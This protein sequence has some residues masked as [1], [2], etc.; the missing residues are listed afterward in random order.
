M[1]TMNFRRALLGS[2]GLF[3]LFSGTVF[4]QTASNGKTE[5]VIVTSQRRAQ[6][7]RDVPLSITVA[8]AAQLER[9]HIDTV[10][11]IARVSPAV[12]FVD[13][14]PGGGA[15]I[16]GLGTQVFSSSAEASVGI[17]VDGVPQGNVNQSNLFDMARVEVLRGP[18][19]NL[20]GQSASAGVINMVTGAP[21]LNVYSGKI[22]VDL[23]F[24]GTAGS[25]YGQQ[26]VQAVVNIPITSQ[27]ALRVAAFGN[28]VVGV[29]HDNYTGWDN[30]D[31][32]VGF[33]AR[34]RYEFSSDF[35]VTLNAD[36]DRDHNRGENTFT[37]SYTP[38]PA[39]P[40]DNTVAAEEACG[41]VPTSKNTA[42][43][44]PL[45][46]Y[47]VA[48]NGGGSIDLEYN[49]GS[50]NYSS[51]TAF[52]ED[53]SGPNAA[54]ISDLNGLIPQ[55]FNPYGYSNAQQASEELR[56]TN[57]SGQKLEYTAGLYFQD[58]NSHGGGSGTMVDLDIPFFADFTS[59]NQAVTST[60]IKSEAIFGQ[61]DYNFLPQ[62]HV[63][64]GGRAT[65]ESL[66]TSS[67]LYSQSFD[68]PLGSGAVVS[69]VKPLSDDVDNVSGRFG[70]NY[71]PIE[72]TMIYGSVATGFKGPQLNNSD[73][74]AAPYIV[75]PEKP[76]AFELG[77]KTAVLNNR[78]AIDA[79][80]FD[81]YVK[82]YQGQICTF[83]NGAL[84]CG[85]SSIAHV[86]SKGAE[87]D[88]Y[89]RVLSN[90]T[91]NAG[92]IYDHVT[93]PTGYL[94]EDGTSLS[95]QQLAGAPRNKLTFSGE[96]TYNLPHEYQGFVD[97]D[98]V[99]KSL[100][101]VYP[102]ANSIYNLKAHTTMDARI[103]VRTPDDRYK[104]A[105]FVRNAFD[106][107]QPVNIYPG[108]NDGT[109]TKQSQQGERVT[110]LSFDAT[111]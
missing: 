96:Y 46:N 62:W 86:I 19:G 80:L 87:I 54:D 57:P 69:A 84:Q 30:W 5:E 105:I 72:S 36:M 97:V 66:S 33:R 99:Y 43:C 28:N 107:P 7:L 47:G 71:K 14:A 45:A 77:V 16:R 67:Q 3:A 35:N 34:Y 92:Y 81:D 73:A 11:D 78:L 4:A 49:G 94:G 25:K 10:Q 98:A 68:P 88:V 6:R 101:R 29:L 20:F 75:A 60:K 79:N 104:L 41:I 65:H 2:A 89:G 109:M 52:R 82:D 102:S 40:A 31:E 1:M 51:I 76:L 74:S 22:H 9:Q 63:V 8:T 38:P 21:V 111:F 103:G 44:S 64:L 91:V 55:V 37:Q 85:A 42:S 53:K 23:A 58:Y 39:S 93:Y 13:G 18:Q 100:Q 56:L 108:I 70:L 83:P 90:L 59:I 50:L 61:V 32:D 27:S 26:V 24:K 15:E 110:G 12:E 106:Q 95:G 17:V 48:T